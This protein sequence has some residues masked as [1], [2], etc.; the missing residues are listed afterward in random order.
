M[1]NETAGLHDVRDGRNQTRTSVQR[2]RCPFRNRSPPF[3]VRFLDIDSDVGHSF[4][5]LVYSSNNV[6]T[7]VME[8]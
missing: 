5:Y 7:P 3:S 8:Y 1:S 4:S 6:V 2:V